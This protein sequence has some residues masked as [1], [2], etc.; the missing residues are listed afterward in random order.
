MKQLVATEGNQ[1]K[2]KYDN[3]EACLPEKNLEEN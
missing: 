3:T 2:A 1:E